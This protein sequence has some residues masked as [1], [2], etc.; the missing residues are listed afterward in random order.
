MATYLLTTD[1]Q[2]SVLPG[3][4]AYSPYGFMQATPVPSLEFC[5]QRRDP[6]TGNYPLGNGHR[7]YS[8]TLMRFMSPDSL[9]PFDRGGVNTYAY[10]GGDPVNRI[11]PGAQFWQRLLGAL[12]GTVTGLGAIARTARNEVS[13]LQ[14]QFNSESPYTPT[15]LSNRISNVAFLG[16]SVTG[17]AGNLLEGASSGW[18][19]G[20]LTVGNGLGVGNA[21]GNIV[22][23]LMGNF[24]AMK[25]TWQLMGSAGVPASSVVFGTFVE[26]TGLRMAGEALSYVGRQAQQYAGR[27]AY[28]AG[29][30]YRAW[31]RSGN[32][33][34]TS[35]P[36]PDIRR[37]NSVTR[38][39]SVSRRYSV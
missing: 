3:L 27:L 18:A 32:P 2:R 1:L 24:N 34:P 22:G 21:G 38:E 10:C 14:N 5:G 6:L 26:V 16:T 37:R 35:I 13:R 23:G 19:V 17:V 12:S 9:S 29:E 36:M 20:A 7:F 31:Q 25:E 4:Q 8:P 15:P 11:D 39:N 33:G 28:T 30:A